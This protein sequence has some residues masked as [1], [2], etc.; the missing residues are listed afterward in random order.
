MRYYFHP[1]AEEEFDN[2]VEYYEQRQI[3]LGLEFAEEVYAAIKRIIE[4]PEA[5]AVMS[6][7]T[8]RCLTNRFPFAL[9]YQVKNSAL[10]IIAVANLHRQPGYWRGRLEHDKQISSGKE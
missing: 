10:H 7:N 2:A 4:F 5:W 8:R 1:S 9:I 3:G 6:K